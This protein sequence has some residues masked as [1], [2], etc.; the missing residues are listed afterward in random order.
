MRPLV[1]IGAF[2]AT[3]LAWRWVLDHPPTPALAVALVLAGP[4]VL[5]AATLIGARALRGAPSRDRVRNTTALVHTAVLAPLGLSLIEAARFSGAAVATPD[6]VLRGLGWATMAMCA[7]IVALTVLNLAIQGLGAPSAVALSRRLASGWLYAHTRNPMALSLF[8]LL[9][10]LGVS[11]QSPVFLAFVGILL[12]PAFVTFLRVYEERELTLRF[13]QSYED[14][15]RRVPFLIPRLARLGTR[16]GLAYAWLALTTSVALHVGDEAAH[17][18]LAVYNPTVARVKATLPYLPIP[19][20]TL[21]SW[22]TGLA[23][24][25]AVLLALTPSVLRGYRWTIAAGYVYGVLMLA[26]GLWH[27]TA[28]F[29][30]GRLM[31]GVLSSPLLILASLTLL[32]ALGRQPSVATSLGLRTSAAGGTGGI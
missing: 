15:R 14:Y 28:S 13:G 1:T 11:L 4:A 29:Y 3:V 19:T 16:R 6:P 25:I 18:F 26:N 32:A 30:F 20:F 22:I 5:V 24:A 2:F 31:P 17:D 7:P 9:L 10:G 27:T 23:L 21:A 8:V 12:L